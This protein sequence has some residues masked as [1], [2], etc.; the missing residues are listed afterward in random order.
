[1]EA[2]AKEVGGPLILK[3]TPVEELIKSGWRK[4]K[5]LDIQEA[6]IAFP[7]TL[8]CLYPSIRSDGIIGQHFNL[9]QIPQEVEVNLTTDFALDYHVAI[10]FE[11][12]SI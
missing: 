9:T 12:T 1:M 4:E 3:D 5:T 2:L 6:E 7:H 10:Y 8:Q 11:K